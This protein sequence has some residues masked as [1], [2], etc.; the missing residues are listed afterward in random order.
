MIAKS[1]P[2]KKKDEAT[3]SR[4]VSALFAAILFLIV[5]FL[6]FSNWQMNQRRQRLSAYLQDLKGEIS[7]L[8]KQNEELK[9]GLNPASQESYL[10][11]EA[12]ERFQLKKPGEKVVT[13]LPA[14][15]SPPPS[16]V[17]APKSLLEKIREKLNF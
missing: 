10:E 6:T 1:R 7:T 8:E 9:S 17:E 15:E 14:E 16:P 3:E 13:V 12:R 2:R 4:F 11:K 5:G